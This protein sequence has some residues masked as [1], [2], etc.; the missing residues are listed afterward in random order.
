MQGPKQKVLEAVNRDQNGYLEDV[1][2]MGKVA[3]WIPSLCDPLVTQGYSPVVPGT[4]KLTQHDMASLQELSFRLV[5]TG[6]YIA[7]SDFCPP[8]HCWEALLPTTS[9]LIKQF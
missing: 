6:S 4:A 2:G 5:R 8:K 1:C 9:L 3:K 7:S